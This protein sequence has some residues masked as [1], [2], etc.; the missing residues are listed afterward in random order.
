MEST[1]NNEGVEN[2]S[3]ESI[4]A[5][6]VFPNNKNFNLKLWKSP[7]QNRKN[8][9]VIMINGFMEGVIK[10]DQPNPQAFFK[11]K[12]KLYEIIATELNQK[13]INAIHYPLPYHFERSID[14][15]AKELLKINGEF[16]YNGGFSQVIDD[17][18]ILI[19]DIIENPTKYGL[20]KNPG[21]H[22]IGY[23]IGGIA[24]IGTAYEITQRKSDFKFS[25]LSVLLSAW[26]LNNIKAE[27]IS[28]AFQ[29]EITVE[30]WNRL[31]QDM[32]RVRNNPSVSALYKYLFWEEGEPI[33]FS[34][35]AHKMLFIH[36]HNDEIFSVADTH[37]LQKMVLNEMNR[38]TIINIPSK[39]LIHL[40]SKV[41]SG[42]IANFIEGDF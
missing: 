20:D 40:N 3:F 36:G 11:R 34:E 26:N 38:L 21:I 13:N 27:N 28:L 10:K 42:Y 17:M 4:G 2:I 35:V 9:I 37:R 25:S 12:R 32:E 7:S 22:L 29:N 31:M 41:L 1:I 39:H 8:E 30:D 33:R 19:D 14:I 23:S 16:L 15:S 5:L 24:A 18:A 6:K